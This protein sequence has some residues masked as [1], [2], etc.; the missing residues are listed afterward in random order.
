MPQATIVVAVET[1]LEEI[2]AGERG[3][4]CEE[5]D[6]NGAGSCVEDDGGGRWGFSCVG[7]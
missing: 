3:L 5:G 4:R 7:C 2:A 6:G 1:Q